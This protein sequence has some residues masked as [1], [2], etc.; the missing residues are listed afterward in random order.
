LKDCRAVTNSA[1]VFL[2]KVAGDEVVADLV[3]AGGLSCG[4]FRLPRAL[5]P[6]VRGG[7]GIADGFGQHLTK[8][9]LGLRWFPPAC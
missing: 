2:G 3:D 1:L 9:S 8:F 6:V 5:R 4:L 7:L